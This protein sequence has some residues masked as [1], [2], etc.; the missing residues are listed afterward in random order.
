MGTTS[1]LIIALWISL[2]VIST[3]SLGADPGTVPEI[4]R[5]AL[6]LYLTSEEAYRMVR[7]E[8]GSALFLDVRSV[9]EVQ[10]VGM[11]AEVDANV[12]Y[13]LQSEW[14]EWDEV[15]HNFKL[16]V[17]SNFAAE[18][19]KRLAAKG[20]HPTDPVILI[21]RSGDRSAKAAV[22]LAQLGYTKVY[23]VVDGFEGD[24]AKD[25]S[26][27]GRR[28]VNGWKNAHLPWSYELNREK[29]YNPEK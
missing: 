7:A 24:L 2:G 14:N 5:T 4:K 16:E 19:G 1:T 15:R 13:M 10:F 9:G 21:C 26:D 25:G 8:P 23:S 28:T 18:V 17:N 6:G 20:L 11:P 3:A 27:K 12:P 22:L 29:M